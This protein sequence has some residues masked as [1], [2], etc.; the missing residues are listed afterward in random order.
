MRVTVK[1]VNPTGQVVFINGTHEGDKFAA[2][3]HKN[4]QKAAYNG[5]MQDSL[6]EGDVVEI[7]TKINGAYINIEKYNGKVGKVTQEAPPPSG[8]KGSGTASGSG[9]WREPDEIIMGECV[10]SAMRACIGMLHHGS[11]KKTVTPDAFAEFVTGMAVQFYVTVKDPHKN[12][13][14]NSGNSEESGNPADEEGLPN[15][16][17]DPINDDIPF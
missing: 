5:I 4:F 6:V 1:S 8:S 17:T 14:L 16:T 2:S 9:K 10:S 7:D 3:A 11:I 12:M 13:A 15:P